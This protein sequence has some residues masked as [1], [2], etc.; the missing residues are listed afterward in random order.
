MIQP[1]PQ[2]LLDLAAAMRPDWDREQTSLALVAARNAGWEWTRTVLAVA[3]LLCDEKARPQDLAAA[4]R[5]PFEKVA[6]S[7]P[8]AE[9]RQIRERVET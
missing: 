5:K 8:S 9:W 6:G 1:A 3:R 7:G 2:Q 4:A